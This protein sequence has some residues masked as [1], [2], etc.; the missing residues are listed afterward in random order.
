MWIGQLSGRQGSTVA[1]HGRFSSFFRNRVMPVNPRTPA[2]T[3][4]RDAMTALTQQWKSLTAAQRDAW[5]QLAQLVPLRNAQGVR[6]IL[7]GHTFYIRFNLTRRTVSL[8]R[9]DDAPPAVEQP[10]SF[11]ANA[12]VLN[13]TG[14][15]MTTAP[16]IIDG[17]GTNFFT[18]WA[19]QFL[20]P[21]IA[22]FGTS[23]YRLLARFAGDP[24]GATSIIPSYEAVFGNGW[25]TMVGMRISIKV[26]GISDTGFEGSSIE[27][28]A[29]IV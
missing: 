8:A 27:T 26:I 22:F 7:P 24:L 29:L 13:G 17:T 25:R 10:P 5:T 16:V 18:V 12:L 23:D 1:T 11:T 15:I 21:G 3:L 19:T 28:S 9:I 2:Q 20:S 14:A 6:I 4:V